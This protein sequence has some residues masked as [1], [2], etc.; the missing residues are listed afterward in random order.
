MP[1]RTSPIHRRNFVLLTAFLGAWTAIIVGRLI[2]LQIFEHQS[3]LQKARRQQEQTVE[4]SPVRG[5][6]Y[7]R[8]QRP[9]AMSVEVES[10][11]AVPSEITE[12]EPT[13]RL[14]ANV[15]DLNAKELAKKLEGD[16]S[17]SWVKRKVTAR[18]ADRIRQL[19]LKG[20]HFQKESKRFY[21]KR[22]LAAHVLGHVGVDDQGLAGIELVYDKAIRGRPGEMIME[23]DARRRWFGRTGR[24]P[25]PGENLVLT[26]DEGIQYIAERELDAVMAESRAR[27]GSV[28]VEDPRTGEILALAN[29]PTF[30]PNTYAE[31]GE[32]AMRNFAIGGNYE[33]GSIFKIVTMAAAFEEGLAT[34]DETMDCQMGVISVAGHRINDWKAFG[35][36]TVEQAFENSSDVCAIK[37]AMRVGSKNFY[38]YIRSFGFGSPT[39]IELP[40]EA[41]GLSRPPERWWKASIGAIAMGQEIGVTPLQ[42]VAATSAIANDGIWV[43]PSIIRENQSDSDVQPADASEP[44]IARESRRIVSLQTAARMQRLM[45]TVVRTGTGKSAKPKGYTAAGKTGTA[46]KLD[47]ATGTYSTRDHIASFIGYTPAESPQFAMIVM[48][49]SPRGKYHGGDVAAPVFRRIAEQALAYRNI[50]SHEAQPAVSLAAYKPKPFR[51]SGLSGDTG[52]STQFREGIPGLI[53]PDFVG[54]GVRSVTTRALESRLPVHIEGNGVAYEQEPSPGEIL[55]AGEKIVI[56]FRIGGAGAPEPPHPKVAA[57]ALPS[58]PIPSAV[59]A[60]LPANG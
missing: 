56:R 59:A 22:E 11:F 29:R 12:G 5:V 30:N 44:V 7:D 60:A 6:I 19:N 8:N 47:P 28:I 32:N 34:P 15:L 14:L 48:L 55:P 37:L 51:E 24:P 18:E 40:G 26:L 27:A 35:I 17:F 38:R 4:I 31:A 58:P 57:P 53:V 16:R 54:Q 39:G 50:P 25:S 23:R 9:L 21:P 33:P 36:L 13:A 43:K 49:D 41:R 45:E 52:E 42:M 46:Q 1:K 3:F 2:Q 10:V 20:I